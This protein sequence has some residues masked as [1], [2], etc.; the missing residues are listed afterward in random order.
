MFVF[1]F[2]CKGIVP[3]IES[4]YVAKV[5]PQAHVM[6]MISA[7]KRSWINRVSAC[8]FFAGCGNNRVQHLFFQIARIQIGSEIFIV[9]KYI[10]F[11]LTL[12]CLKVTCPFILAAFIKKH[13]KARK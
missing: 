4:V 3:E 12:S 13:D 1:R 10:Y 5:E 8:N 2:Y 11:L 9:N 6:W 7:F